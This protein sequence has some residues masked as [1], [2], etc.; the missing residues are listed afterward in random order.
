[1]IRGG[2]GGGHI[3]LH[4]SEIRYRERKAWLKKPMGSDL[5]PLFKGS[6]IQATGCE[7]NPI[8]NDRGLAG[9]RVLPASQA[10]LTSLP[11]NVV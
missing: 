11:A 7:G 9:F 6:L 3:A 4:P 2:E 8:G 10:A 5:C 1:M